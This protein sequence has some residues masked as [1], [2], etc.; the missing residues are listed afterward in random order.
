MKWLELIAVLELAT[1]VDLVG[2][3]RFVTVATRVFELSEAFGLLLS[4]V[5]RLPRSE[6]RRLS[7]PLFLSACS[8]ASRVVDIEDLSMQSLL[9]DGC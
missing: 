2:M 8:K 5:G 9:P 7:P 1:V 6:R 3:L 4:L